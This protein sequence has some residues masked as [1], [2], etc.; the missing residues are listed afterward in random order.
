MN[1]QTDKEL[2]DFLANAPKEFSDNEKIKKFQLKNGDFIHCV[3]WNMHFYIT[4]TD[5][6]KILVWR[7]QNAG[8]Q[9]V[10]LKKFEEGVFSD[11]RNLKPGIDATLEGPRSDF[12][13]FLYKNGCIRTQKKQKVFFWYSVPHDALF[14]DAL[15]RDLRRETNLYA[16]SKYYNKNG[17]N[18]Q[19]NPNFESWQQDMPLPQQMMSLQQQMIP[20][21]LINQPGI[22]NGQ[23]IFEKQ[24]PE[25]GIR[26]QQY[27]PNDRPV[28][29]FP[30]STFSE[31]TFPENTFPDNN[32]RNG[33]P[34]DAFSE[35]NQRSGRPV[36]AFSENNQRSGRPVDALFPDNNQRSGRPVDALFPDNNQ[37]NGRPVDALFSE[38]NQ[39]SGRPVDAFSENNQRNGRQIPPSFERAPFNNSESFENMPR[40]TFESSFNEQQKTFSDSQHFEQQ[41]TF[42][43]SQHFDQQRDFHQSQRGFINQSYQNETFGNEFTKQFED[44]F[45]QQFGQ[46]FIDDQN[47]YDVENFNEN[48][49]ENYEPFEQGFEQGFEPQFNEQFERQPQFSGH[50][51]FDGQQFEN[52]DFIEPNF[53]SKDFQM[54]K[55]E[56]KKQFQIFENDQIVKNEKKKEIDDEQIMMPELDDETFEPDMIIPNKGGKSEQ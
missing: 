2:Y 24:V 38:N 53:D 49:N 51:Q 46:D 9:I 52:Q 44:D 17:Y 35:N 34:V 21:H 11:L 47:N 32:Q 33:R 25:K 55:K 56:F 10:S 36:D 20:P 50:P 4:G 26:T 22:E 28:D 31:S 27:H 12:L 16:Y 13:E 7:F 37:R 19:M 23:Y 18:M 30:D 14:C 15:E 41:K 6:V 1:L 29:V 8:R 54:D 3:L 45:N 40:P 42:S 48:F 5:I 39:R 43:D